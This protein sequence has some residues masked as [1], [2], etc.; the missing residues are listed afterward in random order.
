MS[1]I[2]DHDAPAEPGHVWKFCERPEDWEQGD[3]FWCWCG[4]EF[5]A[6]EADD[7]E[8]GYH[9]GVWMQVP[10]PELAEVPIPELAGLN[11]YVRVTYS[12]DAGVEG[13]MSGVYD[14]FT[15]FKHALEEMAYAN[16]IQLDR[17]DIFNDMGE[18]ED[19]FI[20]PD[21]RYVILDMLSCID[22]HVMVVDE[23][24]LDIYELTMRPKAKSVV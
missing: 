9:G 11:V 8:D 2:L 1:I 7:H 3:N 17:F 22:T 21:G 4:K 24:E 13:E 19:T 6:N 10:I 18:P 15:P 23:E 14:I 12:T 16:D 5:V 20:L